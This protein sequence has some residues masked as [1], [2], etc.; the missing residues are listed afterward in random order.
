MVSWR[1]RLG[2]HESA[3]AC[4]RESLLLL[5]ERDDK[6]CTTVTLDAL[7]QLALLQRRPERAVRLFAAAAMLQKSIVV[8]V[9]PAVRAN[10]E[11]AL[12]AARAARGDSSYSTVWNEAWLMSLEQ[13]MHYALESPDPA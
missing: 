2:N 11:R 8:E 6:P 12:A 13:A 4:L 10:E 9:L 5:R 7:A 3:S 1:K